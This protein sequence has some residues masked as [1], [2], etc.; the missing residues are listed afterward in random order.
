MAASLRQVLA[1]MD[2]MREDMHAMMDVLQR[3][4]VALGALRAVEEQQ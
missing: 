1:D 2:A 4:D 3:A